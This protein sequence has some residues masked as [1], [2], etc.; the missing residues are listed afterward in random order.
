M[1]PL[2]SAN[3]EVIVIGAGPYGLS[4]A[5]HLSRRGIA[6]RIFGGPYGELAERH[7]ERHVS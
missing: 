3:P 5:A 7:A 4:I 6:F 2:G 1:A